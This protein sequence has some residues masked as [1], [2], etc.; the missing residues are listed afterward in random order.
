MSMWRD[1]P[2]PSTFLKLLAGRR[3]AIEEAISDAFVA[4]LNSSLTQILQSTYLG[5]SNM[6]EANALAIHPTTGDVYVA[7]E[8]S[9]TNFPNRAGGAQ[10]SNMAEALT[11]LWQG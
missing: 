6:D 4:R 8:T 9:S 7:G 3:Q 5:G 10:A 2:I 1:V 11:A